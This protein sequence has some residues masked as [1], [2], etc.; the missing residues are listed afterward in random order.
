MALYSLA[1][2][3]N[4]PDGT[5]IQAGYL[6]EIGGALVRN[7]QANVGNGTV[8]KGGRGYNTASGAGNT[9]F[10]NQPTAPPAGADYVVSA[11][12]YIASTAVTSIG[13]Q[14]RAST[15]ALTYYRF[16]YA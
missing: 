16:F 8:S 4:F 10:H 9:V 6:P 2:F 5:D 7:P 3:Q 1:T 11:D 15:S 12:L 14:A 13:I